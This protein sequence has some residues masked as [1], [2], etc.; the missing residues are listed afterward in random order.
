MPDVLKL[1]EAQHALRAQGKE[2]GE[3]RGQ[4]IACRSMN[5]QLVAVLESLCDAWDKCGED[6]DLD[7]TGGI[8]TI[9]D[10]WEEARSLVTLA[11]EVVL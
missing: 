11:K 8:N 1:R 7:C 9:D 2:T 5:K 6:G 10:V 3:M 4:L